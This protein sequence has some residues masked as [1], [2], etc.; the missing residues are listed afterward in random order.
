MVICL[1]RGA[2]GHKLWVERVC[3]C[4]VSGIGRHSFQYRADVIVCLCQ[5]FI[6]FARTPG[7]STPV[8]RRIVSHSTKRMSAALAAVCSRGSVSDQVLL[9]VSAAAGPSVVQRWR[10]ASLPAFTCS[11]SRLYHPSVFKNISVPGLVPWH[12]RRSPV[13]YSPASSGS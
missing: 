8:T 11:P 1:E 4:V 3:V 2:D 13:N 9:D 7:T 5:Y 12:Y 6:S 10:A